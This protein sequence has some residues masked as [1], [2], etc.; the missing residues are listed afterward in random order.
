MTIQA[1]G[2]IPDWRDTGD[3]AQL[4]LARGHVHAVA[5][6]PDRYRGGAG[7][8]ATHG[9][10]VI[11]LDDGFQF[12]TLAREADIV[13]LDVRN[14]LGYN[15]LLP[16]GTLRE[17]AGAL[18]RA[19]LF[20]LTHASDE[21]AQHT[22]E[23]MDRLQ[24]DYPHTPVVMSHHEPVDTL[25]Y[26]TRQTRG[27]DHLQRKTLCTLSAIGS[28]ESFERTAET[29]SGNQALAIRYS[30]HHAFAIEELEETETAAQRHNCD[31]VVTTEKDAVRIPRDFQPRM[32]WLVL[33]IGISLSQGRDH[34]QNI[35]DNLE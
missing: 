14:P 18:A 6:D 32:P 12:I 31:A 10:N 35:I 30:D 22:G 33:R 16:R 15:R 8:C 1:G 29:L 3:E 7:L 11:L 17:P 27:L 5:V 9:C 34:I 24:R 20:W 26:D 21:N 19:T 23:L 13:C 25:E 4:F 2:P 28:P